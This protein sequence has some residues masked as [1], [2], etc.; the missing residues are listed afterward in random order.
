MKLKLQQYIAFMDYALKDVRKDIVDNWTISRQGFHNWIT[1][2]TFVE[3]DFDQQTGEIFYIVTKQ[4][5]IIE[6]RK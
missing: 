3:V 2:K 5:H 1:K 4:D 6:K